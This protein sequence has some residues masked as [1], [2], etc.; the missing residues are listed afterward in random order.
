MRRDIK[1]PYTLGP[2]GPF[3]EDLHEYCGWQSKM[4]AGLV[5]GV[6]QEA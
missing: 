1:D 3:V 2:L 5:F 4:K 6:T